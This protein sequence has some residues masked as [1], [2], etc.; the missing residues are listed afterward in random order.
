M[1]ATLPTALQATAQQ[2]AFHPANVAAHPGS[3]MAGVTALAITAGQALAVG[4]PTNAWGWFLFVLQLAGAA[5][6]IF[7]K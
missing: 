5:G 2:P 4:T 7:G 6:A 3:T 1:S